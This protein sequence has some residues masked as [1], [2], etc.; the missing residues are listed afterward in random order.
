M[1]AESPILD[2]PETYHG[3]YAMIKGSM[4]S[5]L[6]KYV[7][8][9]T[10]ETYDEPEDIT[11]DSIRE[12]ATTLRE[13]TIAEKTVYANLRVASKHDRSQYQRYLAEEAKLRSRIMS[14]TTEA[15]RALL[16]AENT[17]RE[18]IVEL[19]AST[20][21]TDHQLSE[22]IQARHRILLG[23]KYVEWPS[24]GPGKWL[25]EWKKLMLDCKIWCP[26]QQATWAQDFNRVWVE[27]PEAT[28]LC[29]R[30][31][32]AIRDKKP[33]EWNVFAAARELQHEWDQ[34][35][36]R[37][38]MKIAGKTKVTRAAFTAQPRFDGSTSEAQP[39]IIIPNPEPQT[40]TLTVDR[41]RNRSTSRKRTGTESTQKEG[42]QR[43]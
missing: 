3:W 13:L 16:R 34:R 5:D 28:W 6:W 12:G 29:Q 17:V 18:W 23:A 25:V 7:D 22:L 10:V 37:S 40:N 43:G 35:A 19:Q 21:P 15:T 2:G 32:Q 30:I 31:I 39:E 1:A 24:A 14:S 9:D 42:R 27:V 4:P 26:A 8:P 33:E 38:S 20:R 11:F 41:T 36:I